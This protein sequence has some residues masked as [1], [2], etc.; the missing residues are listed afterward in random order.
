VTKYIIN[1]IK[2]MRKKEEVQIKKPRSYTKAE[3]VI[4]P[5][6]PKQ[7]W[8]LLTLSELLAKNPTVW[9]LIWAAFW[10]FILLTLVFKTI[11]SMLNS[12]LTSSIYGNIN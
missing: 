1:K 6:S 7:T 12:I 9:G 3:P 10:R 2:I 5:R 4:E 11:I 8:H